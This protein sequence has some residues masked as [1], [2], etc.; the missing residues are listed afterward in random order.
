M[1]K[2]SAILLCAI[3]FVIPLSGCGDNSAASQNH[4]ETISAPPTETPVSTTEE[5]AAIKPANPDPAPAESAEPEEELD[6][7][8]AYAAYL[9]IY[10]E[11]TW[12]IVRY[13]WCAGDG[14]VA[15]CNVIGDATPEFFFFTVPSVKGYEAY[16][17]IYTYENNGAVEIF[18]EGI[19]I[20]AGAGTSYCLFTTTD[21]EVF[22]YIRSA[23]GQ[24][25]FSFTKLE[26]D[27]Q[28]RMVPAGTFLREENKKFMQDDAEITMS[29]YRTLANSLMGKM[30]DVVI[31]SC[32][33]FDEPWDKISQLGS[34]AMSAEDAVEFLIVES[35]QSGPSVVIATDSP[36]QDQAIAYML[37]HVVAEWPDE[38][39]DV[40]MVAK[41]CSFTATVSDRLLDNEPIFLIEFSLESVGEGKALVFSDGTIISGRK[42][43]FS[44]YKGYFDK[45]PFPA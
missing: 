2:V 18:H 4:P 19:D 14:P 21:G 43:E 17:S 29:E 7:T 9:Q 36:G 12:D 34:S 38:N 11:Y 32:T 5:P 33:E 42:A 30:R 3:L 15:F 13:N 23:D 22:L 20:L 24:R 8:D 10:R 6:F 1:K 40:D 45:W 37:P 28:G 31:W 44:N 16:L 39:L 27:A 25:V 26:L 41:Y 35:G